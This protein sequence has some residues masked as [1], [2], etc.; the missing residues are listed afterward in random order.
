MR[1][2]TGVGAAMVVVA[3]ALATALPAS[4]QEG[5]GQSTI[6][7]I[8]VQTEDNFL[9]FGRRG[10]SLGDEFVFHSD[11]RQ[12]GESIGHDGGTCTVTSLEEGPDGEFQ[13]VATLW[14]DE[15]QITVQGLVQFS[16]EEFEIAI[17][18]GTGAY[19][20]AAGHLT[21]VPRTERRARLTISLLT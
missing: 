4:S 5:R 8:E 14:F 15:G 20:G 21:I 18:G 1:R 7:V 2:L 9:D 17:T 6:R 13:C 19:E 11:L 12:E 16:D 3:L 10:P